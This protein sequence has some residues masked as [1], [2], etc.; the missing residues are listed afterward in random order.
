V[1]TSGAKDDN[2]KHDQKE[3]ADKTDQKI[4]NEEY[5]PH[6]GAK[7][8]GNTMMGMNN[9]LASGMYRASINQPGTDVEG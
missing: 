7:S 6:T 4:G 8:L 1:E 5:S 3:V 2:G 9:S